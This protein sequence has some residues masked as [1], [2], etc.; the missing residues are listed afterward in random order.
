M[1]AYA[2]ILRKIYCAYVKESK[3]KIG[4]QFVEEQK[5]NYNGTIFIIGEIIEIILP[6][7]FIAEDGYVDIEKAGTIAISGL[8]GYHGTK[9][10]ARLSY[11]KLSKE[12]QIL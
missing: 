7:E 2:G 12:S 10:F 9:R 8:D 4:L 6:D 5:I 1:R 3:I 11:A